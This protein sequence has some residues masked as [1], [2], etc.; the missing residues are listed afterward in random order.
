M[1][2][3]RIRDGFRCFHNPCHHMTY[4]NGSKGILYKELPTDAPRPEKEEDNKLSTSDG[5]ATQTVAND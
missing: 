1:Q 4:Y 5:G 2:Q 3:Y